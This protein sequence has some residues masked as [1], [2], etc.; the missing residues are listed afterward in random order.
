MLFY[1]YC[2]VLCIDFVAL[3]IDCV[4]LCILYCSLY[5]V[6]TAVAQWLI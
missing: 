3:C 5:I 2:V 1:V 4:V 6:G